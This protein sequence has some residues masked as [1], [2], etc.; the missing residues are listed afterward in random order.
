MLKGRS[1]RF[2]CYRCCQ[3]FWD[4]P[5]LEKHLE[6]KKCL[7]AWSAPDAVLPDSPQKLEFKSYNDM[8]KH[9]CVAVYDL[10]CAT[11]R[12]TGCQDQV[13]SAGYW[14]EHNQTV[15]INRGEDPAFWL[16][17][18][19]LQHAWVFLKQEPLEMVIS[20]EQERQHRAARRC[21]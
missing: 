15:E 7:G 18:R 8:L 9:P 10:E 20:E 11:D 12:E 6:A 21:H 16:I 1:N 2:Y 4:E 19:L 17:T 13:V 3:S 5:V 14:V